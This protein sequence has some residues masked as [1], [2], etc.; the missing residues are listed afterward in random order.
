MTRP[1][2]SQEIF[3][4]DVSYLLVGGLGGIGRA[5]ALWMADKGAKNL[6]ILSRSGLANSSAQ[7]LIQ[8]LSEKG[9]HV[10]IHACDITNESE[11]QQMFL[12]ISWG[13]PPIRGIVQGAMV[14][15]VIFYES[16]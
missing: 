12:D 16:P 13:A 15:K 5:I 11:V 6:I 9:V 7:S 3:R 4:P 2:I 14:L 10:D 8:K 1:K